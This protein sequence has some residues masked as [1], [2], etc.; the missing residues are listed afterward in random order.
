MLNRDEARIELNEVF[1]ANFYTDGGDEFVPSNGTTVL[2]GTHFQYIIDTVSTDDSQLYDQLCFHNIFLYNGHAA[3]GTRQVN[4]LS[5]I[6][7]FVVMPH[8]LPQS[9]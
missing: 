2:A 5:V 9:C 6:S 4:V 1:S 8:L 7:F 3:T